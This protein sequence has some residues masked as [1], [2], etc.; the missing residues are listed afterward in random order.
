MIS[1]NVDIIIG[2]GLHGMTLLTAVNG[3][4]ESQEE[5]RCASRQRMK[6]AYVLS[7]IQHPWFT[8]R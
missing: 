6:F 8:F 4:K 5:K 7:L 3:R 2:S 1:S